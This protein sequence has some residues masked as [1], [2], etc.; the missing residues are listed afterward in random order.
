MR[1][2]GDDLDRRTRRRATAAVVILAVGLVVAV[3]APIV[4]GDEFVPHPRWTGRGVSVE[5]LPNGLKEYS[6]EDP[7][8]VP[9]GGSGLP[10]VFLDD[11]VTGGL[12]KLATSDPRWIAATVALV[13]IPLWFWWW[14]RSAKSFA[15]GIGAFTSAATTAALVVLTWPADAY[16][17]AHALIAAPVAYLAA[18]LVAP[19][20]RVTDDDQPVEGYRP[21]TERIAPPSPKMS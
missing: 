3:A 16:C 4:G 14:R 6:F 9:G 21:T 17:A 7:S 15:R 11:T 5:L 18:F 12:L 20:P 8:F 10:V 1:A 13:A 2:V 19:D